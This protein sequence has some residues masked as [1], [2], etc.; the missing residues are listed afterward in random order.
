MDARRPAS[1]CR[2][3]G[4]RWMHFDEEAGY[5]QSD[6]TLAVAVHDPAQPWAVVQTD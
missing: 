3:N 5:G 2:A 4:K 6:T 1:L